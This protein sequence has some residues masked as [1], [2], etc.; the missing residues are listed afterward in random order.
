[1]GYFIKNVIIIHIINN[2]IN[3]IMYQIYN[4]HRSYRV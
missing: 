1:M 4:K 2:S 3:F